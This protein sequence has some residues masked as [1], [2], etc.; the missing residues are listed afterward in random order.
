MEADDRT[1][2]YE[3]EKGMEKE[4]INLWYRQADCLQTFELYC[5]MCKDAKNNKSIMSIDLVIGGDHGKGE[6]IASININAKFTPE[7]NITRIFRLTNVQCKKDNGEIL[8]NTVVNSIGYRLKNFCAG[9]FLG[10]IHE[11]KT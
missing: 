1:Y 2:E 11:G 5:M 6:F 3:K 9:L 8:G 10:W 7:R 4:N